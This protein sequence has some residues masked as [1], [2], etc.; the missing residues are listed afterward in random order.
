MPVS[1]DHAVMEGAA[2]DRR[3]LMGSMSVGWSDL[4]SW[5]Q[6][7]AA[8]GGTGAGRV[9]PPNEP[10]RAGEADLI[11]ERQNG[12]IA[13]AEGPRDILASSPVALLEG[14]AAKREPVDE[15]IARVAEWEERQ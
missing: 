10:A 4:G 7:I 5:T 3:V 14:A 1:I 2:R 13:V 12:R 15:L 8:L 11:V 9:V 6:L